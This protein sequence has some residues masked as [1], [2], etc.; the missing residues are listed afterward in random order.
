MSDALTLLS[1]AGFPATEVLGAGMEGTVAVLDE[2]RAVKLWDFRDRTDIDRLRVF[3]DAVAESG[4]ALAVPRILEVA[5]VEGRM[6]T[7]QARL[8]GE[9]LADADAVVDVLAALADVPVH[10]D[11][12]VLPVPD[13]ERPFDPTV[14]FARSLADLVERRAALLTG[15]VG[16]HTVAALADDLR[17]L[18]PR[19]P[20]LVHGDLGPGN[21]LAV[22]GRPTA[23]L[24][25]GYVSTVGD[26]AFDAAVAAAVADM[27]G[28]RSAATTARIDALTRARFGYEE[29][30]LAL[31]RA[32]YG[33]VTASL[34]V[35]APDQP[36][37]R[38]CL[39]WLSRL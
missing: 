10:P 29:R 2:E 26:P 9:P 11:M 24:D 17:H 15:H 8:H 19:P 30:R 28:P 31:Y 18:A 37:F 23:L 34:L 16:A 22:D 4:F 27:F 3:Y 20:R 25:F 1:A 33:L 12:A 38:W 39:G 32:A 35:A 21:V 13:G 36:H 14:P 6:I 7:V 5:E